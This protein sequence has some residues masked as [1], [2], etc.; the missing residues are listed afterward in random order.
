MKDAE[1]WKVNKQ[2]SNADLHLLP[3]LMATAAAIGL[4]FGAQHYLVD[5]AGALLPLPALHV[6]TA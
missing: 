2:T 1:Q 6:C 3:L 4:V 5:P